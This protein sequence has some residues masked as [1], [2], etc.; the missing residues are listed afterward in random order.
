MSRL[1]ANLAL[2]LAAALWGLGNVPQKTVLDHL[3][4]FSAVG[5][6]CLIGAVF[7]LPLVTRE[8]QTHAAPPTR[9]FFTSL[10]RVGGLFSVAIVLQQIAFLGTTVTNASF[11]ISTAA[12]MTPLAA[13]LLFGERVATVVW[14]AA[15]STV[16]G[17]LLLTGGVANFTPGDCVVLMSAGCY[18]LWTVELGRHMRSHGRPLATMAMQFFAAAAIALPIGVLLGNLSPASALNAW[19]ELLTLG[20]FST[21]VP[22]GIQTIA[23]QYTPASHAA[24][25]VSAECVFGALGAALFL[26]EVISPIGAL[27][28]TMMLGAIVY[29]TL[30]TGDGDR[31]APIVAPR[32]EVR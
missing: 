25:I 15:A 30:S 22:F 19:P 11:L 32:E 14:F 20:F 21:A 13:W 7:V 17:A 16:A 18:A 3:D 28:A 8:N 24:V 23:Q 12:V 4:P 1:H 6:R 31:D 2:L 10:A 27:G 5:I 26:A 9:P 29:L